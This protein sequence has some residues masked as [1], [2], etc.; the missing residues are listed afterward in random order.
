MKNFSRWT[1]YLCTDYLEHA[2]VCN[3]ADYRK[4]NLLANSLQITPL[5]ISALSEIS[6]CLTQANNKTDR[7]FSFHGNCV[8]AKSIC[9]LATCAWV[10]VWWQFSVNL[11]LLWLLPS[12]SGVGGNR[13]GLEGKH[14]GTARRG[15]SSSCLYCH[16]H[17]NWIS[18]SIM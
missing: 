17:C 7:S 16:L 8:S 14:L 18:L 13:M 12:E 2:Y 4:I 1:Y 3:V 15:N 10:G 11:S 5:L 9:L 6:I